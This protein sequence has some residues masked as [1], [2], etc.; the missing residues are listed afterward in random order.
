MAQKPVTKNLPADLPENWTEGQIISP[1]G[2]E[3]GLDQQHGYNY[4]MEQVNNAQDAIKEIND[5]FENLASLDPEGKVP[6][7]ELPDMNYQPKTETLEVSS[8]L[9]MDDSVPVYDTSE[10][11]SKRITIQNLKSALGVQSPTL[12]VTA[13]AG[14]SLVVTDGTTTLN[15]TGTTSFSLPN[16]GTWTITA[17]LSGQQAEQEVQVTGALLYSVDMRIASSIAITTPPTKTAYIVGDTF[18]P[19]GVV[20]TATF[21]DQTTADVSDDATYAPT[22]M[23]EGVSQVTF[24]VV[25][26]GQTLTANQAVTVDRIALTAVPSQSNTLTYNGQAQSPTFNN[27]ETDKMTISGTQSATNAGTYQVSFTP[28]ARYKWPDGT[29]SAKTVN[30]SIGKATGSLSLSSHS[31]SVNNSSP[32]AQVTATKSGTGAV[33]ASASPSGIVNVSVSGNKITITGVA[34]GSATVTVNVAADTNYTAPSSQ[35]ISVDCSMISPTLADNT[36]A[37]IKA[38][39]TANQGANYWDVGDT[40]SV[41]LNGSFVGTAYNNKVVDAFIL[42]FNHNSS[43]EG[44]GRIHFQLGKIGQVQVALCDSNYKNTGSSAGFRMNLSNTNSG[45]WKD[46]YMR[47]NVLG[48]S[49]TPSSPPA[50][51]LLAVVESGLRNALKSVNK[52]TDNTGGGSNSSGNVT[53]TTDYFFLLAEFEVFGSRGGANQYEQNQQAQYDFYKSGNAKIRYRDTATSTAVWWWLRS[54]SYDHSGSFRLVTADGG[55][56]DYFA[57]SSGGLAPGFCV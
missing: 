53:F 24:S 3:A 36:W 38:I 2:T 48:N 52:W 14:T 57:S 29:T 55:W 5:A 19:D 18:Q 56:T 32:T 15:G 13:L 27:Y 47:K 37:D 4:L 35:T 42:G 40:K 51:S 10:K 25:I 20:I 45:G 50:N 23:A 28:G 31:V 8:T 22:V 34:T 7:D 12:N 49:G 43:R 11:A 30:W 21:A 17:T 1:G 33:S 46:S 16:V 41:T 26:G 6:S 39:S 44:T 9:A 54:P